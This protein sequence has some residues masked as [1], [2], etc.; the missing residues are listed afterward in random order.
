MVAQAT[1]NCTIHENPADAQEPAMTTTQRG[2]ET[3]LLL[4]ISLNFI[5]K[6][7]QQQNG[8]FLGFCSYSFL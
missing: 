4:P 7:R 6:H 2:G 5:L 1:A 3:S 8:T